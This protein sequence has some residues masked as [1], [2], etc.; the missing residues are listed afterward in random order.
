MDCS[1]RNL[2]LSDRSVWEAACS[3][4]GGCVQITVTAAA[5]ALVVPGLGLEATSNMSHAALAAD[6]RGPHKDRIEIKR[7]GSSDVKV[8]ITLEQEF[9]PPAFKLSKGLSEV[10]TLPYR[11]I[12]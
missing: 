11:R 3:K 10:I 8:G 9:T 1:L 5:S 7:M 6:Y 12:Q 2:L 4:A